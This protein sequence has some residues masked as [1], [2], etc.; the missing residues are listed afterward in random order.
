MAED[1]AR[2]VLEELRDF[3]S[4]TRDSFKSFSVSLGLTDDKAENAH[5]RIDAFQ[6]KALG[7]AIGSGLGGGALFSF[8][9]HVV[10][11]LPK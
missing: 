6:N 9:Q 1:L 7:I 10:Q 11:S 2:V 5:K 4:E 3:R 8:I